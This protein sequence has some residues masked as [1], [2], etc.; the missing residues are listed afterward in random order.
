MRQLVLYYM[1]SILEYTKCFTVYFMSWKNCKMRYLVLY[2]TVMCKMQD[3]YL[4][5]ETG[6]HGKMINCTENR[7]KRLNVAAL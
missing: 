2:Y 7:I 4:G 6:K 3:W 1:A 5:L